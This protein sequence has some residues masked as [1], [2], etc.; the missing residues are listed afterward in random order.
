MSYFNLM[1]VLIRAFFN[2]P[3]QDLV[4]SRKSSASSSESA[5]RSATRNNKL[6]RHDERSIKSVKDKIALFSSSK[7]VGR[8]HHQSSEDVAS[9]SSEILS[10]LGPG[11][12]LTRAY[13]HGDVRFEA[14]GDRRQQSYNARETRAAEMSGNGRGSRAAQARQGR[15]QSLMEIGSTK[16]YFS[17]H[18]AGINQTLPKRH[19]V[20]YQR[21]RSAVSK[22]TSVIPESVQ[23]NNNNGDC[24]GERSSPGSSDIW[25]EERGKENVSKGRRD[26][27]LPGVKTDSGGGTTSPPIL[28]SVQGPRVPVI[29]PRG[30]KQ[31]HQGQES[32]MRGGTVNNTNNVMEA[33]SRH[34]AEMQ[35]QQSRR[36]TSI[37]EFRA[38]EAR[39]LGGKSTSSP[40]QKPSPVAYSGSG[41]ITSL[42]KPASR[43]SS[44]TIA[45]RKKSFE[46]MSRG[47]IGSSAVGPVCKRV[48]MGSSCN[49]R[50]QHHA[51]QD[52]LAVR[53]SS[54][55]TL[56]EGS[57]NHFSSVSSMAS[58]ASWRSSRD[59][60][61][62]DMVVPP[63]PE[64]SVVTN[65]RRSSRSEADGGSRVTTP[66]K[67]TTNQTDNTGTNAMQN[68]EQAQ[69]T[70]RPTEKRSS[71]SLDRRDKVSKPFGKYNF[72]SSDFAAEESAKRDECSEERWLALEKKYTLNQRPQD[73]TLT[74]KPGSSL[75]SPNSG[76]SIRELTERFESQSPEESVASL[77]QPPTSTCKP[78]ALDDNPPKIDEAAS[79]R[80]SDQVP[81]F[82]WLEESLQASKPFFY[83]PEESTEWE[84]FDPSE[85]EFSNF[86]R[87][88]PM[89]SSPMPMARS[90]DQ[91]RKFSAP[92]ATDG[93]DVMMRQRRHSIP[94][95]P[96][97]LVDGK[98]VEIGD[99]T[100]TVYSS[101]TNSRGSSQA[102]LLSDVG[103]SVS[104]NGDVL[105]SSPSTSVA[106]GSSL[107]KSPLLPMRTTSSGVSSRGAVEGASGKDDR[108]C[109]SV[110]DIRRAFEKAEQSL[111][112]SMAAS[113]DCGASSPGTS[114]S[115]TA[116]RGA[117]GKA[118]SSSSSSGGLSA[119]SHNRMSSLDSTTSEESSI[120]TPHYYGSV[121]SLLSGPTSNLKDHYGSISS[122]ASS[123]SLISPQVLLQYSTTCMY[124]QPWPGTY[125]ARS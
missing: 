27:V 99:H 120:P 116:L 62:E 123:T 29:S 117:Q 118:G 80:L 14:S 47:C 39:E 103:C 90:H 11:K 110:N 88:A 96:S 53:R 100:G 22:L 119:P 78:T 49:Q 30:P 37:S 43:S 102:D 3:L 113:S 24:V 23:E 56:V 40:Q 16:Y 36:K 12:F 25:T 35:Q 10:Q 125:L 44:F 76:K 108:R 61:C 79:F 64:S 41:T 104:Q 38:I 66:T 107:L 1:F 67:T 122:L 59:T 52:C 81:N 2:E 106:D 111:S 84:S 75:T 50:L 89:T 91:G 46:A 70:V 8:P 114:S 51:S 85:T 4:L 65:S 21:R 68:H 54:R 74:P 55:D 58:N 45:E 94:S 13:T 83:L 57:G 26:S 109:V 20:E 63:C 32:R 92:V 93:E 86:R 42:G 121:S 18:S 28:A 112:Q 6:L 5:E 101:S 97:S 15:S 87:M 82:S 115:T 71:V 98:G 34:R 77:S 31:Q 69:A 7:S 72:G 73:L 33:I 124:M 48:S 105:I 17:Q 9:V 95:R 19:E 60:I